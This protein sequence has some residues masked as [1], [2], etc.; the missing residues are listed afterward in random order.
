MRA[1]DANDHLAVT[2]AAEAA[3]R[4]EE[5]VKYLTMARGKVRDA[6]IETELVYALAM[7]NRLGDLETFVARPNLAQIQSV[8]DRC[9]VAKL[10]P[11]ARILFSAIA[12]YSKLA[13]TLIHLGEHAAAVDSAKKANNLRVWQEVMEACLE[14]GQFGLAQSCGTHLVVHADELDRLINTYESRGFFNEAIALL[15]ASI[16]LE[17]SHMGIFTEL[18]V[19]LAKYRSERLMDHLTLYWSRINIPKTIAACAEAHLW[20]ALVF[21]YLHHDDHDRAVSVMIEHPVETWDHDRLAK[22][23]SKSSN[24]ET[25]YR[26]IDWYHQEQPLLLADLLMANAGRIDPSRIVD[27]FKKLGQLP[28]IKSYLIATQPSHITAVN[29]ALNELFL[30]EEDAAAL[31]ASFDRS[32]RF[33][34][35]AWAAK[36]REHHRQDIRRQ[37]ARLY[38]MHGNWKEAVQVLKTE[39]LFTEAI[40]TA[41]ASRDLTLAEDLLRHFV[42]TLGDS[43][44]F[45]GCLYSC[46]DLIRPDVALELAWSAGWTDLAMPYMCQVLR[47]YHEK[48]GKLEAALGDPISTSV[49]G[50]LA[51]VSTGATMTYAG[52]PQK[53][54]SASASLAASQPGT[55]QQRSNMPIN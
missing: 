8:A 53:R 18:A 21:L 25:L 49:A 24:P 22:A 32:D 45:S 26:A 35:V 41:A 34:Q 43:S 51:S 2:K 27:M 3:G 47:S 54:P 10:Y 20:S 12:N 28:L 44:L 15:E 40:K 30:G 11:A 19:L 50:G 33:D 42:T 1:E 6:S 31:Q 14:T 16:G 7:T 38:T 23:L 55:P 46:M 52:A 29:Q 39:A 13:T 37:A 48:L 4:Y 36:L 5:L 17:R 9:Y